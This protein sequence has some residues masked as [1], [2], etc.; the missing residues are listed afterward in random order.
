MTPLCWLRRMAPISTL[1]AACARPPAAEAPGVDFS[2]VDDHVRASTRATDASTTVRAPTSYDRGV[3]VIEPAPDRV[4]RPPHRRVD[5][6]FQAAELASAM[7][8]LA[9]AGRFN[10]VVEDAL[11]AKVSATLRGVDAYDAMVMLATAHGATVR[12]EG[13]VVIVGKR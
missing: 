6:T 13:N 1:L 8:L 11:V 12:Y 4:P 9:D 5:V 7:Q 2:A 3:R 10:L